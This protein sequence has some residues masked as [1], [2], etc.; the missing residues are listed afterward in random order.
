MT[1]SKS[2]GGRYGFTFAR[3]R[4]WKKLF[5]TT[6][7]ICLLNLKPLSKITEVL[8]EG[9]LQEARGPRTLSMPSSSSD[10]PKTIILVIL[11]FSDR[12]L[13]SNQVFTSFRQFD[14]AFVDSLFEFNGRYICR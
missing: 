14:N 4:S 3:S 5:F 10:L 8:T 13:S 6:G 2:F 7:L 11:L 1:L 9:R 12:K